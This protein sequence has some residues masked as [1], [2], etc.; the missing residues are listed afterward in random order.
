M[1]RALLWAP[2]SP[3]PL[4]LSGIQVPSAAA[5]CSFL[6]EGWVSFHCGSSAW[7]TRVV[8]NDQRGRKEWKSTSHSISLGSIGFCW[9][10]QGQSESRA[11]QAGGRAS[12]LE[13]PALLGLS[14]SL[15]MRMLPLPGDQEETEAQRDLSSYVTWREGLHFSLPGRDGAG[16]CTQPPCLLRRVGAASREGSWAGSQ[17][18][19]LAP[20]SL[21]LS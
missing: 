14:V 7:H 5:V 21:C 3:L 9:P 2:C 18:P 16:V 11:G 10:G 8:L 6:R 15:E 20:G 13:I 1:I 17:E 19:V 12:H 4:F